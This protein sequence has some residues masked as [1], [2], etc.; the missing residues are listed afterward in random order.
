M[1]APPLFSTTVSLGPR[2]GRALRLIVRTTCLLADAQAACDSARLLP[3]SGVHGEGRGCRLSGPTD[4]RQSPVDRWA[5]AASGRSTCSFGQV[6]PLSLI[7]LCRAWL[8]GRMWRT[9]P[10]AR[11]THP[12]LLSSL[13]PFREGKPRKGNLAVEEMDPAGR[14]EARRAQGRPERSSP[15]LLWAEL[16]CSAPSWQSLLTSR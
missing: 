1:L 14:N 13:V 12:W 6:N 9:E 2:T 10:G 15:Q 11:S 4:V 3:N 7:F 5:E 16:G 8:W